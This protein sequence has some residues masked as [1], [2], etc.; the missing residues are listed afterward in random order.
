MSD[1]RGYQSGL[2]IVFLG[3]GPDVYLQFGPHFTVIVSVQGVNGSK[4]VPNNYVFLNGLPAW[5]LMGFRNYV[6]PER[7]DRTPA[8]FWTTNGLICPILKDFWLGT[9]RVLIFT[10]SRHIHTKHAFASLRHKRR[11]PQWK[12]HQS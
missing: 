8:N 12:D 9:R 1:T 7:V 11:L 4:H 10:R 3:S 5:Q 2:N 6:V